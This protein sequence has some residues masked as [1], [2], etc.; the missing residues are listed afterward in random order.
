MIR[1]GVASRRRWP[2]SSASVARCDFMAGALM[3]KGAILDLGLVLGPTEGAVSPT[4]SLIAANRAAPAENQRTRS[5]RARVAAKPRLRR[6]EDQ[7][8][9]RAPR[10]E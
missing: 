3:G 2:E 4:I 1:R 10:S 6:T 5:R 8:P 9:R 7:V